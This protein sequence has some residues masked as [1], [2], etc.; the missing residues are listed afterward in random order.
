MRK[1]V[2]VLVLCLAVGVQ[3]AGAAKP[4]PISEAKKVLLSALNDLHLGRYG[5]L[6]DLLHPGEQAWETRDEFIA[7]MP[8]VRAYEESFGF[9]WDEP[10]KIDK[11]RKPDRTTIPWT[12]VDNFADAVKVRSVNM[13]VRFR[14]GRTSSRTVTYWNR[15]YLDGGQWK[16]S[17]GGSLFDKCDEKLGKPPHFVPAARG[18]IDR[19]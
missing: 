3:S 19:S 2:A 6:H 17:L 1:A 5:E 14:T 11:V 10:I 8:Q 9:P 4:P 13:L 16:Y 12:T 18:P 15:V 7:C